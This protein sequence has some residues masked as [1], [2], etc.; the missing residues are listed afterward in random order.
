MGKRISILIIEFL[1]AICIF[2]NNNI[3]AANTLE[4]QKIEDEQL[5]ALIYETEEYKSGNYYLMIGRNDLGYYKILFL[6][7]TDT[8]KVYIDNFS[9]NDYRVYYSEPVSQVWYNAD[10]N[11]TSL[12]LKNKDFTENGNKFYNS[13]SLEFYSDFNIYSDNTYTN[14]FFEGNSSFSFS[15]KT[16]MF[17]PFINMINNN[18]N[19]LL[20]FGLVLMGII[21]VVFLIPKIIYKFF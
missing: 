12:K 11:P 18:L 6:K 10:K 1:L 17:E 4:P 19:V 8:L 9:G 15:L 16:K 2:S 3:F 20:T 14:L 7:K 5:F 21:I 13:N